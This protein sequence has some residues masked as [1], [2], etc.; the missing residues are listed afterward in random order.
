MGLAGYIS[1]GDTYMVDL[2]PLRPKFNKNDYLMK[3]GVFSFFLINLV[4]T[5][6]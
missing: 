5:A 4:S 1:L 3:A 2:I 6:I